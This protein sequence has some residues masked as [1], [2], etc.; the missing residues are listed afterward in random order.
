M[1]LPYNESLVEM[2]ATVFELNSVT[3]TLSYFLVCLFFSLRNSNQLLLL[4]SYYGKVIHLTR[5]SMKM[6]SVGVYIIYCS[7]SHHCR[8][9]SMFWETIRI[10][11]YRE[12]AT[13]VKYASIRL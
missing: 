12:S 2:T 3:V 8:A 6:L 7:I 10:H 4:G 5:Q 9:I 13:L 1:S 11:S